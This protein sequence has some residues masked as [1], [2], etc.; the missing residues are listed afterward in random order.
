MAIKEENEITVKVMCTKNE[1]I[2]HLTDNGFKKCR[3]FTLDDYYFIPKDLD[4][5]K[6][7]TREI[8]SKAVIIRYIVNEENVVQ[9]ITFKIKDIADNGDIINQQ[10]ISCDIYKIE[11]A[12]KL[13]KAIGYNEIMNI[14]EDDVTYSKDGFELAI[15]DIKNGDILIEI[16]TESNTEWDTIEK[17]KAR[18]SEIN[19]PIEQEKYFI[20]KAEVELDKILKR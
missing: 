7:T 4:L 5:E 12:K 3:E 14:K 19:L 17:I 16:E 8:I 20:K 13:F 6:M 1:L 2:K 15:K 10:A 18:I 11:D 9:K